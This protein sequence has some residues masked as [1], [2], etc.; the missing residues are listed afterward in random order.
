MVEVD[1][2]WFPALFLALCIMVRSC[3]VLTCWVLG[4]PEAL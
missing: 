1:L 3:R 2:V 4:M